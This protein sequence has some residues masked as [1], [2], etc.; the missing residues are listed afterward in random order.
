[1]MAFNECCA[2]L[3]CQTITEKKRLYLKAQDKLTD[4]LFFYDASACN[5]CRVQYCY[6]ISLC[7]TIADNVSKQSD[8]SSNFLMVSPPLQN[9]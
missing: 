4:F 8:I 9:S 7:L 5:A 1:M 2:E 3:T 6:G